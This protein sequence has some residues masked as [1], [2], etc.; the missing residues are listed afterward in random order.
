MI[1][2]ANACAVEMGEPAFEVNAD[3]RD[4]LN[5]I[6]NYLRNPIPRLGL[7]FWGEAGTGKTL[8]M[9]MFRR[10][11]KHIHKKGLVEMNAKY[12]RANYYQESKDDRYTVAYKC[13]LFS[14]LVIN[15]LG[16]ERPFS[17][18]EDIIQ[19]VMFDR[20]EQGKTTHGT[21]NLTPAEL[22]A[23]YNDDKNR[24]LD[25]FTVM[26]QYIEVKGKSMRKPLI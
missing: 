10:S 9:E 15:D 24:M 22:I 16:F 21:T 18:G 23:R 1:V 17:S 19:T 3:N 14:N 8:M 4:A 12:I 26:F 2:F 6:Y 11:M 13:H 5:S 7:I 20:F 25:R